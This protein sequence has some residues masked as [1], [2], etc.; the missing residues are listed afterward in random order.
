M[1]IYQR[2]S[3]GFK[4]DGHIIL[5]PSNIPSDHRENMFMPRQLNYLEMGKSWN[6]IDSMYIVIVEFYF[7]S[8]IRIVSGRF[9]SE[10]D[11]ELFTLDMV[12]DECSP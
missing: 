4:F 3:C 7:F 10:M 1:P 5:L 8:L 9:F 11:P 6:H 2:V 12:T